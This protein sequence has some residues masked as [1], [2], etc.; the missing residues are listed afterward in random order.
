MLFN[1]RDSQSEGYKILSQQRQILSPIAENK[2]LS[3]GTFIPVNRRCQIQSVRACIKS[4]VKS[5]DSGP[6]LSRGMEPSHVLFINWIWSIAKQ[7][8]RLGEAALDHYWYANGTRLWFENALLHVINCPTNKSKWLGRGD[9]ASEARRYPF[10]RFRRPRW[11]MFIHDRR[12]YDFD[13]R[14]TFHVA[15]SKSAHK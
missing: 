6:I 15:P 1:F 8:R 13:L 11:E 5:W 12:I 3:R 9:P 14:E 7:N 4:N 10:T 2:I